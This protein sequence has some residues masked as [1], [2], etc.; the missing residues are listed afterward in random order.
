MITMTVMTHIRLDISVIQ[1]IH[2]DKIR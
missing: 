2:L 1:R